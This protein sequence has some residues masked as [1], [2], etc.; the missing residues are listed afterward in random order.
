TADRDSGRRGRAEQRRS[1]AHQY[2]LC[3][4]LHEHGGQLGVPLLSRAGGAI[5]TIAAP[6]VDPRTAQDVASQ[7]KQL[8]RDYA[9]DYPGEGVEPVSGELVP[10]SR[11]AALVGVFARFA[12][13]IIERLNRVPD[14]NQLAFFDLLGASRLPPQPSRVPLTFSLAK[15]S[16]SPGVVPAGPPIASPPA[17]GGKDTGVFETE[18]ELR[19]PPPGWACAVRRGP[20]VGDP[21]GVV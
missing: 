2:R 20:R 12:E 11:G 16:A 10:D 19:V 13:L 17:E 4:P 7:I 5:M 1:D 14:K 6:L 3:D 21:A 18:R 15:G 8:L 9:P